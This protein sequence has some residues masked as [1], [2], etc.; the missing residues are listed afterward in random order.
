VHAG[1]LEKGASEWG[2]TSDLG[3]AHGIWGGVTDRQFISVGVRFGHVM[4]GP[5]GPGGLRGRLAL[6]VEAS[7]LFVMFQEPTTFGFSSV[8]QGRHY[9]DVATKL[10]PFISAGAGLLLTDKKTPPGARLNFT[11]QIGAGVAMEDRGGRVFTIEYRLH[12]I[13][14]ASRADEN[15]GI[16]SSVFQFGIS[17]PIGNKGP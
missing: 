1:F 3:M 9:L 16:N 7:P 8:V 5:R 14:N 15:P 6:N 11:P 13:S 12:H 4:S 2:L 17:F 10:V